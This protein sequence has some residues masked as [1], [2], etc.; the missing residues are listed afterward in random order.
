ML[1]CSILAKAL[2]EH[3]GNG[4]YQRQLEFSKLAEE[5]FPRKL[6]LLTIFTL[7]F[8]FQCSNMAAIV[9]SAQTMD[10]TL[11]AMF[12]KTC[13]MVVVTVGQDSQVTW[14]APVLCVHRRG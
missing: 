6:Y 14:D 5:I 13:A 1:V 11:L 4:K 10:S 12:G 2:S 9:E 8:T 3:P 7:I